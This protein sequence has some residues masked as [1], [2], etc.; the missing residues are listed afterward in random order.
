MHNLSIV[1]DER[2][3]NIMPDRLSERPDGFLRTRRDVH[4]RWFDCHGNDLPLLTSKRKLMQAEQGPLVG[5]LLEEHLRV[6]Y[7]CKVVDVSFNYTF[8]VTYI[9]Q[10]GGS[11]LHAQSVWPRK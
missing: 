4:R 6:A 9:S 1:L 3:A 11:S 8:V 2:A 7:C 10:V 5:W